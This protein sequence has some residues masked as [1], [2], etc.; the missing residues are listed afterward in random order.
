MN[1]VFYIVGGLI[2]LLVI[3]KIIRHKQREGKVIHIVEEF[4]TGCKKCLKTCRRDV[5]S[6]VKDG[7]HTYIVV[8]EP[9]NCSACGDCVKTCKF[10]ALEIINKKNL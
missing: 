2:L 1:V 7:K 3:G 10:R 6:A 5:L 4:C 8:K 9:D